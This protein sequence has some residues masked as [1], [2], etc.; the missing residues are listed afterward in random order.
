MRRSSTFDQTFLGHL[1]E[2]RKRIIYILIFFVTVLIAALV[3]VGN[4]YNFLVLP[5]HG[6]KLT[7]L[8]PGDVVSVYLMI[9]GFAALAV[10]TPFL[11]W[12]LWLFVGPGLREQERR[13][14]LCLIAP[15]FIM[16]VLG[17]CFGF[18]IV[19]PEIYHFLRQLALVR[20]HF[21]ITATEYFSFLFDVVL[22]FALVF[23]LPVVV[24]F[25]TRIGILTPKWMRKVRRYAYFVCIVLGTLISP[26]ELISHLSVTVPMILLYEISIGISALAYR[27]KQRADAL[28][29]TAGRADG[30][31]G[32]AHA[33]SR[34]EQAV[35][36]MAPDVIGIDDG[37]PLGGSAREASVPLSHA[38]GS[39]RIIPSRKGID[40]EERE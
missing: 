28:W 40:L 23:E 7:V 34:E 33:D 5:A 36:H 22:P 12:Q 35:A 39:G 30:G 37:N 26:P 25:L 6:Q 4:I 8:G 1:E 32:V 16:F 2:L 11:L 9:A 24:L 10:T 21:M 15:V 29:D 19:F 17:A 38:A 31:D 27:K 13:Y 18:F 14:A 20:Y 3:F